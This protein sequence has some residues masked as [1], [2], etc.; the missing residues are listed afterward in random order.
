MSACLTTTTEAPVAYRTTLDIVRLVG[1]FE[2]CAL[3]RAEWTHA[4][5]L[6]VALWYHLTTPPAD[7]VDRIRFGIKRFNAAQGIVTTPTGGY[8]ETMTLFWIALV[9]KYLRELPGRDYSFVGLANGLIARYGDKGLPLTYYTRE[10]LFS[11]KARSTWVTP[12]RR[13]LE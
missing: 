2:S 9:A 4:A 13:T 1:D 10:R 3:S 6:T 7:V 12:D 5:H 8:H 11:P